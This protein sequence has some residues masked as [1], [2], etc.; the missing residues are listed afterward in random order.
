MFKII[1]RKVVF[2]LLCSCLLLP[3]IATAED[4]AAGS[5]SELTQD[6]E[7]YLQQEE[8]I[9]AADTTV[10]VE[11]VEQKHEVPPVPPAQPACG[12]VTRGEHVVAEWGGCPVP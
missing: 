2:A 10:P 7:E 1:C 4:E 9:D 12:M 5:N 11:Q 3:V 8:V 6:S